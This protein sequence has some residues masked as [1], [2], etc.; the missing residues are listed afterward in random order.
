MIYRYRSTGNASDR[1]RG[2]P[3]PP[4]QPHPHG[5]DIPSTHCRG[6]GNL[7]TVS[8]NTLPE[9]CFLLRWHGHRGLSPRTARP[10]G[11]GREEAAERPGGG[12]DLQIP[13][14]GKH[15]RQGKGRSAPSPSAPPPRGRFPIDAV[16]CKAST[17]ASVRNRRR[18]CFLSVHGY[19]ANRHALPAPSRGGGRRRWK[20]RVVGVIYRYRST[21]NASDRGGGR[22]LRLPPPRQPHPHGGDIPSTHCWGRDNLSTVSVNTLPE[23]CSCSDGTAIGGYRHALPAPSRGGGRRRWKRRVVGVIYKYR[24]T[25]NTSDRGGDVSASPLP[26]SPSPTGAIPHKRTAGEE[27]TSLPSV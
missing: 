27:A 10:L 14:N 1:G 17:R 26:V 4:R 13:F 15:E 24:S 3:P 7:S 6:R 16:P 20:R 23:S 12:G 19:L 8:V 21:G 25:G 18:S 5:G 22:R 9:S 11:R 2:V